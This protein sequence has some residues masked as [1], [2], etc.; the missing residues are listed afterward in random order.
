MTFFSTLA[1][2]L[3]LLAMTILVRIAWE[4]GGLLAKVIGV[5]PCDTDSESK[6]EVTP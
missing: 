4:F 2:L 6:K 3:G 1:L 5:L